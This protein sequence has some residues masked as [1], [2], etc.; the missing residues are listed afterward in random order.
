MTNSPAE[1]PRSEQPVDQQSADVAPKI[2]SKTLSEFLLADK[3]PARPFVQAVAK[4]PILADD[5]LMRAREIVDAQPVKMAKV[6]ELARTAGQHVPPPSSLL[7]W[8][9]QIVRTR[10]P[11]LSQWS[12]NPEQNPREAF[13]EL[14]V[15]A[16]PRLKAKGDRAGRQLAEACLVTG[17]SLLV[18]RRSLGPL[19]ALQ[20]IAEAESKA[21]PKTRAA[22]SEGGVARIINRSGV[23][24]LQEL[25]QAV[26]LSEAEIAFAQEQQRS[27]MMLV[28]NLRREKEALEERQRILDGE[29][30]NMRTE[31]RKRDEQ[32]TKLF[33][34][35]EGSETRALQDQRALKARFRRQIGESLGGLVNDA[36][37]S[38]DADPPHLNVTRERLEIARE[39]IRKELEWLDKSSD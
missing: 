25:A 20:T 30:E 38:M 15:W 2:V 9:E 33:N 24:Q 3:E 6:T 14:V 5:D 21:R 1:G 17:L 32:I 36:W 27:A 19:P 28:D 22:S 26:S 11:A 8:C 16:Y 10:D 39:T 29:L 13:H 35:L 12:L 18:N 7:R 37:D 4:G 34:S 31:L 23:K